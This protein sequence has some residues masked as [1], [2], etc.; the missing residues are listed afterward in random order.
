MHLLAAATLVL[1]SAVAPAPV[2]ESSLPVVPQM[3]ALSGYYPV[4]TT[5]FHLVDTS[6]PDPWRPDQSRELMVTVSYPATVH[7]GQTAPWATPAA[8]AAG[9][10]ILS[11][12]AFFDLPPEPPVAWGDI[13]RHAFA[14]APVRPG[15]WPVVLFSPG[16][17]STREMHANVVDDLASHGYA[18]VS[19]SHTY[20][21]MLVEFPGGRL[22][23]SLITNQ[24]PAT[25]R[26][27]LDT[28][29]ADLRFVL[30]TLPGRLPWL[31]FTRV[32]AMGHSY[33][34]FTAA[35]AMLHDPR[36]RAGIDV[37]G[38]L[39]L[40]VGATYLPGDVVQQGLDR[41]LLLFG[42]DFGAA[43]QSHVDT[44]VTR[45]WAEIWPNLRGWKRDLHLDNG[46][47]HS[48]SDFQWLLPQL[49]ATP[50]RR[51]LIIG[52]IDPT[53]S[54]LVQHTYYPAFFG[55]HLQGRWTPLFETSCF[56]EARFIP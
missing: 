4:G 17:Q 39:E 26:T 12:P 7:S 41:P 1:V 47:H 14:G 40:T 28:R 6:R 31:D 10:A 20:E 22:A 42:G 30:D 54:L 27:A 16:F 35:E 37:D 44:T 15:R 18:V 21:S 48:F 32:G 53:R 23:P 51:A 11:S 25:M 36:I 9:G 38:P 52:A 46:A 49:P 29:V 8:A 34:G 2:S 24:E 55:L 5:D 56:P 13:R 45:S 43:E 50:Q 3:P 33:G 19:V